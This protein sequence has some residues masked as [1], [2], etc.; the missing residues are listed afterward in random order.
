MDTPSLLGRLKFEL[1][2]A[3]ALLKKNWSS[4]HSSVDQR[5]LNMAESSHSNSKKRGRTDEESSHGGLSLDSSVAPP[6]KRSATAG[7]VGSNNPSFDPNENQEEDL[8]Q[9]FITGEEMADDGA[10]K[11]KQKSVTL[12]AADELLLA[13]SL[14][15]IVKAR[16]PGAT[17]AGARRGAGASRAGSVPI[18]R[19]SAHQAT[20]DT[21][22]A[23]GLYSEEPA[24]IQVQVG[25][26]GR[27]I[28]N[29][30]SQILPQFTTPDVVRTEVEGNNVHITS[31]T[32]AKRSRSEKW[33]PQDVELLYEA[34]A[35]CG[36]DFSMVEVFFPTRTRAHVKARFKK[37]EKTHPER[38]SAAIAERRPIN[39][40]EFKELIAIKKQA[41]MDP[42]AARAAQFAARMAQAAASGTPKPAS[43]VP[44]DEVEAETDAELLAEHA[45]S[46]QEAPHAEVEQFAAPVEDLPAVPA[47]AVPAAIDDDDEDLLGIS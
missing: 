47:V 46:V 27:I 31:A 19:H 7:A 20:Q 43:P 16:V 17:E 21:D 45:P 37:E 1:N 13:G 5:T 33:T 28:I 29:Q 3:R 35:M 14:S 4:R 15:S 39:V 2:L 22:P 36:T 40:K 10:G 23:L 9:A 11:D 6:N 12:S 30:E 25:A 8:F 42:E 41:S 26:D 18:V 34:L 44:S 32:Y 24:S 38:V